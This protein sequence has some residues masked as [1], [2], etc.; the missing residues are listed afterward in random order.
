MFSKTLDFT[1]PFDDLILRLRGEVFSDPEN[2]DTKKQFIV[3]QLHLLRV[4]YIEMLRG[5]APTD[6]QKTPGTR[7]LTLR[8]A[9]FGHGDD[10][11]KV[12]NEYFN[13]VNVLNQF[14][15]VLSGQ[16]GEQG[17]ILNGARIYYFRNKVIEHWD[18]YANTSASAGYTWVF[19]KIAVPLVGRFHMFE[20]LKNRQAQLRA[21]FS[22]HGVIYD[23]AFDGV[24][25][26]NDLVITEK[27]YTAL[28]AINPDFKGIPNSITDLLFDVGFPLPILSIEDYSEEL[29]QILASRIN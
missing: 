7:Q 10:A 4:I 17:L 20:E 18:N 6:E 14:N 21:E 1:S 12:K 15:R 26:S 23:V 8:E 5:R 27:K 22:K 11:A 3:N 13:F 29:A 19:D 2:I 24:S 28:E 9:V 16:H 25:A